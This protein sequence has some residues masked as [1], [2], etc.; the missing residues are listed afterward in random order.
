MFNST[1]VM[2]GFGVIFALAGVLVCVPRSAGRS[3][4]ETKMLLRPVEVAPVLGIATVLSFAGAAIEQ[5]VP[6]GPV[7][8]LMSELLLG[9]LGV[10][11]LWMFVL[12]VIGGRRR[13]KRET[14]DPSDMADS[15]K[16]PWLFS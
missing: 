9:G 12:S 6:R 13:H 2:I 15:A 8:D 5:F 10:L 16:D 4:A 11:L 7:Y 1:T 14:R 3:L